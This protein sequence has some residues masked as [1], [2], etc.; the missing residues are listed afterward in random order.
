MRTRI[1]L[2]W[3]G[4]AIILIALAGTRNRPLNA[5]KQ[6]YR[7]VR[8]DPMENAPPIVA[9][10]TVVLGGFRGILADLLWL[11]LS[12]LQEQGKYFELV[13]LA[14][15]IT[16][17]EP[18]FPEVWAFH[19]WNLAYNVSVLFDQPQDR[20]RWV[21]SG[22]ELLR[23]QG[24]VYNPGEAQLYRE[25]GWLFQHK[26]GADYDQA[27]VFYKQS[28]AREMTE[29]FGGSRPDFENWIHAAPATPAYERAQYLI[30]N[31]KLNPAVM[32]E[33]DRLY[34]PFDWRLPY[35]HAVYWAWRG[36][37]YAEGFERVALMRMIL[38]SQAAAFRQGRLVTGP[39][40]RAFALAPDIALLPKV[41]STFQRA[42]AEFPEVASF[43]ESYPY[44]LAEGVLMLY[45]GGRE[46]EAKLLFKEL[47]EMRDFDEA[48]GGFDSFV[49]HS[50]V[51][52]LGRDE[53]NAI[54]TALEAAASSS[55]H[56]KLLGEEELAA[57]YRRLT[58]FL[59]Q[60]YAQ[61][62]D[63][64]RGRNAPALPPLEKIFEKAAREA[65]AFHRAERTGSGS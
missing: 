20:W 1:H 63:S 5:L 54:H 58:E 21:R 8:T 10:T 26:L 64:S 46:D 45:V 30:R 39:D 2:V 29:I 65:E 19:A 52:R 27:H 40:G 31:Y 23:D 7:L 22:I 62:A 60:Y 25:L 59:W 13:Q 37:P 55:A 56:W 48:Q 44:L 14:D 36:R 4:L 41:R 3:L 33:V 6:E 53:D 61:H 49:F 16:K 11:R 28:W 35:A 12:V 42:M 15:W 9:F 32:H 38:Q 57:G 50:F 43:R 24:L 17:L 51:E 18:R 47:A 34:G